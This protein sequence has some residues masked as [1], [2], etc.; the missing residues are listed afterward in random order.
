[1]TTHWRSWLTTRSAR[2][3]RTESSDRAGRRLLVPAACILLLA[4]AAPRA[5]AAD[6]MSPLDIREVKVAGEIG[7]HIDATVN[8]NLLA[9]DVDKVFLQPFR[10]RNLRE[11]YIGLGKLIDATVRFAAY[12]GDPR[13]VALK[14]QLIAEAIKTQEPDGYIGILIPPS[15]V[16]GVYDIHETSHLVLGMANDYRY[17]GEKTS[18][19]AARK[20]ADFIINRWSAEPDRYPGGTGQRANMYGVTTG[21]DAA[22]LTLYEQTKDPRYLDFCVHFKQYELPKWNAAIKIGTNVM[23]D[24]RHCY[25]YMCLCVAQ[26]QLNRIQ[27]DAKLFDQAHRAIDFL[28]RQ[29]GLLT[30]G[31][32]SFH[33]GWHSDQCGTPDVSESCATAYLIR[34]LDRLFRAEADS[35]YGDMMERAVHNALFAAQ[36]PDGRQIRYFSPL[37]GKR[38]YF[39][40]DTFCCPNNFR[41][42]MAELPMMIYYRMEKGLVVNLY[43]AS[44]AKMDLGDGLSLAVRQETDYPRGGDVLVRLDPSRPAAFPLGL[45]IPRWCAKASVTVNDQPIDKAAEPGKLLVIDREWK[46]GDRVRLVMPME[47]R[48]VKG[49]KL[50][51]G[52]AALLRGP[53]LFCLNPARNEKLAGMDLKEITIDP[54]SVEGPIDDATI[55]PGG[56]ACRV[57]AWSPGKW[58]PTTAPDL[59]LLLTEFADPGGEAT[60]LKVPEANAATLV[61]DELMGP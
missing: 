20:L 33:E 60:H 57:R 50:Q 3:A 45:R 51:A 4:V 32:C 21:L 52:R 53:S 24:E 17:F 15:R 13:V 49:R 23:D 44:T 54:A 28:T 47:Y 40:L 30:S 36:S 26:M 9:I 27:P 16:W 37:E 55:R 41:R 25:I 38:V 11:G 46:A 5:V 2:A 58:S 29:D 8:A 48:W 14:K 7:R 18:L 1:M 61:D 43:T 56:Q 34:M 22:L 19:E 31:S 10:A 35:R 42:I 39:N 59:T 12:T 6:A